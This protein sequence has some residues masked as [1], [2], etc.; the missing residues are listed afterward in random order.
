MDDNFINRFVT[1]AIF[2]FLFLV[3]TAL[4]AYVITEYKDADEKDK[5]IFRGI[6]YG[7]ICFIAASFLVGYLIPGNW[8]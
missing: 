5:K 3:V 2:V 8:L 6:G 4:I 7:I 1:G